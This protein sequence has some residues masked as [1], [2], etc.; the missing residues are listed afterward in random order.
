M[1]LH[2]NRNWQIFVLFFPLQAILSSLEFKVFGELRYCLVFGEF[3]ANSYRTV[4]TPLIWTLIFCTDLNQSTVCINFVITYHKF[5]KSKLAYCEFEH[6]LKLTNFHSYAYNILSA[7]YT[8]TTYRQTYWWRQCGPYPS[9]RIP[10]DTRDT[11]L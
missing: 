10:S 9:H 6:T 11:R 3:H 4:C 1:K 5:L 7:E 8:L 2:Y